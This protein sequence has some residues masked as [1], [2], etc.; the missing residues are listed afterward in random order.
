[1]GSEGVTIRPARSSDADGIAAVLQA[2]VMAGKRT[3]PADTGFALT[4][5]IEDPGRIE[6]HV[7]E[8]GDGRV[9]GFQSMKLAEAGNPW[10]APPG[11]AIIGSHIH[12]DAARRGVGASLFRA[13]VAAAR[14]AGVPAIDA[15]IGVTNA[16]GQAYY[17]AMGFRDYRTM[18]GAVCKAFKL[19]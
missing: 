6:C 10:G 11:W 12:P 17:E 15:C 2:L 19:T 5:Y 13:T 4:H 3:R 7:A 14:T 18:E 9:L 8:S 16:E 1:M